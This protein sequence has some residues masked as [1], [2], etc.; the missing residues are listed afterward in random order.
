VSIEGIPAG[1]DALSLGGV[2]VLA[3]WLIFSGKLV[4]IR[5]VQT[6]EK[7]VEYWQQVAEKKDATI[8]TQNETL[9]IQ[10][11]EMAQGFAK[12]MAELQERAGADE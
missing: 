12:L 11:M 8:A 9:N 1:V 4:P 5:Q 2:V 10:T 6:L 7:L 3:V